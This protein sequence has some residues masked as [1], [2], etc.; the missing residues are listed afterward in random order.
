MPGTAACAGTAGA[1]AR[2]SASRTASVPATASRGADG[3]PG[4]AADE[5]VGEGIETLGLQDRDGALDGE[6]D[7]A[8]GPVPLPRHGVVEPEGADLPGQA[9]GGGDLGLR[10]GQRPASS[11][12]RRRC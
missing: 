6:A 1:I 4:I 9:A 10:E 7:V 8:P 2:P 3:G 5:A 11:R 12:G